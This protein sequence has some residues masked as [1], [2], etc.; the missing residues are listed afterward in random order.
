MKTLGRR[1][2]LKWIGAVVA[3]MAIRPFRVLAGSGS[4]NLPSSARSAV[5]TTQHF[6]VGEAQ[7][8][9]ADSVALVAMVQDL[10]ARRQYDA[11]CNDGLSGPDG[12]Y[13]S[14]WIDHV[15][16]EL[17]SRGYAMA[18]IIEQPQLG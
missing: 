5:L 12:P 3:A 14:Q 8:H 7:M 9:T 1:N 13:L 17:E 2:V 4:N 10:H 6:E 16:V 15:S 11:S 18:D